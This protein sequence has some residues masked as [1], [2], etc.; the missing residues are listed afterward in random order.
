MLTELLVSLVILGLGLSALFT[1][2]NWAADTATFA[3]Q[4]EKATSAAQSILAELGRAEPLMDGTR[5]GDLPDGQHWRLS[6]EKPPDSGTDQQHSLQS[7]IVT[8]VVTWRQGG[9]ER[10]LDFRTLM[11]KAEND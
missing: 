5:E 4:Q 3:A 2:V 1:G 11:L 6:V 8:L 7:R 9:A 10:S